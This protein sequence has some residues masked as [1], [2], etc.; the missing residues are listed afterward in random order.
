MN[1]LLLVFAHYYK[2]SII[3]YN[4]KLDVTPSD[5]TVMARNLPKNKDEN[6][7]MKYFMSV[8]PWADV[9]NVNFTY[10]IDKIVKLGTKKLQLQK[11]LNFY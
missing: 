8:F 9:S 3:E 2:I 4:N 7:V 6:D 11:Q 1:L 5:F 10:K